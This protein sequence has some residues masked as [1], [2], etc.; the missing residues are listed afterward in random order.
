LLRIDD[1]RARY[2]LRIDPFIQ[3]AKLTASDAAGGDE[4]GYSVA[5]TSDT[6]VAG[7]PVATVDGRFAQGRH[8]CSS[9]PK[10]LGE[11]D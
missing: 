9:T 1:R 11:R 7:A 3:Q 10:R 5:V 8:T 2:P 6:V 4:L